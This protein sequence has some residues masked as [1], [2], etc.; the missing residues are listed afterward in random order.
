MASASFA[1]VRRGVPGSCLSSCSF[2]L[3]FDYRVFLARHTMTRDPDAPISVHKGETEANGPGSLLDLPT[4]VLIVIA[5]K[6]KWNDVLRLRKVNR[7]FRKISQSRDVWRTIYLRYLGTRIPRPYFLPKPL[8]ICG[9]DDLEKAVV[10]WEAEWPKVIRAKSTVLEFSLPGM[11]QLPSEVD[12]VPGGRWILWGHSDGSVSYSDLENTS[13]NDPFNLL[14]SPPF[15]NEEPLITEVR[16]AV[17]YATEQEEIPDNHHLGC[18]R[19]AVA[20]CR[21]ESLPGERDT[22][23]VDI[24]CLE[25]MYDHNGQ[26][27]G[28]GVKARLATF[29]A[30]WPEVRSDRP[31]ALRGNFLTYGAVHS[32]GLPA[33]AVI[34]DWTEANGK[35]NTGEIE[36]IYIPNCRPMTWGTT[37]RKLVVYDWAREGIRSTARLVAEP[38]LHIESLWQAETVFFG[39]DISVLSLDDP[40]ESRFVLK[41]V[42]S[43]QQIRFPQQPP[44]SGIELM[45]EEP[46]VVQDLVLPSVAGADNPYTVGEFC[47]YHRSV[48]WAMEGGYTMGAR[49]YSWANE[50]RDGQPILSARVSR[51]EFEWKEGFRPCGSDRTFF[52]EVSR[53]VVVLD[54][55]DLWSSHL[56]KF[57]ADLER[58]STL[59]VD[60]VPWGTQQPGLVP[61]VAS[62]QNSLPWDGRS[63]AGDPGLFG[64]A[65]RV[66]LVPVFLASLQPGSSRLSHD[67]DPLSLLDLPTEVLIFIAGELEWDDVPRLGKVNRVFRKISQSRDVWQAIYLRYLGTRIPRPYFLPKPLHLCG[68]NDLEKAVVDWEAE[69]PKVIRAKPTVLEFSFPGMPQLLS[70]MYL[71]PGGRWMLWGRPDGSVL[72]SDLQHD[73][74][75]VSFKSLIPPPFDNDDPLVTK[76]Q[77]AFD[78]ATEQEE[79]PDVHHLSS[80]RVAVATC[81]RGS[82]PSKSK[83]QVDIWCVEVT[84]DD[85]VQAVGLGVKTRIATFHAPGL[86]VSPDRPFAFALKGNLLAYRGDHNLEFPQ[87]AAVLDWTQANGK[88]SAFEIEPVYI[89]NCRPTLLRLLPGSRILVVHEPTGG[90]GRK[91]AVYDW[92]R[93]GINSTRLIAEPHHHSESLWQ[94]QTI[95]FGENMPIL[96]LEDP[97]ESRFV[98]KTFIS[99]QEVRLQLP[100]KPPLSGSQPQEPVVVQELPLPSV[101]GITHQFMVKEYCGY[102]RSVWWAT[103]GKHMGARR[104]SWANEGPDGQPVMSLRESRIEF[105]G[106]GG[107]PSF[108]SD[109][110]F[111]DEVSRRVVLLDVSS[112]KNV[113]N[114]LRLRRKV[115]E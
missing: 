38:H 82:L 59:K 24:W 29:Q 18:F 55:T 94:A 14:I 35:M 72:Y 58:V 114:H 88:M 60:P 30:H 61:L 110:T 106:K 7:V 90:T 78:Y 113:L 66:V 36:Q 11:P 63:A 74:G 112:T 73:S 20:T 6:L 93:E 15:D 80:F 4:E 75:N 32:L 31:L 5:G 8:H 104:Y 91:L 56:G 28:L 39:N 23:Q 12:L 65:R 99:I 48:W 98:L 76:A 1:P 95:F 3:G 43:I 109:R 96:S 108:G 41:T 37:G 97:D 102:H 84:Y 19:L 34:V 105:V 67:S 100:R 46:V 47:G 115:H 83:T 42:S 9:A 86:G 71:V 70:E 13:G 2:L 45:Q 21:R 68:A 79:T 57:E 77:L 62:A 81:Q 25:V 53:R 89:P 101:D 10:D 16:L 85:K 92:G 33:V 103:M 69:W 27:V 26:A 49:R 17:D 40:N 87:F 54:A 22:T 111:F 52:D 64:V 107:F 50:G 51:I 44:L